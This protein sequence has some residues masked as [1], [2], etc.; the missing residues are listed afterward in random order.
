MGKGGQ[1]FGAGRAGGRRKCEDLLPID[2]RR[3]KAHERLQPASAFSWHWSRAGEPLGSV[4]IAVDSC[5][6]TYRAERA[7]VAHRVEF[8]WTPCRF[9]GRRVWFL[10][11]DCGRRCAVV[12]GVDQLSC[13]SCR[14]CMNLA[15]TSKTERVAGATVA[16][17]TQARSE[18]RNDW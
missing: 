7:E 13:L 10:C 11:S 3:L 4:L 18:A 5:G 1:R 12:Y 17:A 2:I 15:Y 16:E 14:F 6:L 8:T 9:G